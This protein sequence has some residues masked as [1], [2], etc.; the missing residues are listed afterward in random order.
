MRMETP[1]RRIMHILAQTRHVLICSKT[2]EIRSIWYLIGDCDSRKNGVSAKFNS[3][4]EAAPANLVK[5]RLY[6][7]YLSYFCPSTA[8]LLPTPGRSV[9]V[10]NGWVI[11]YIENRLHPSVLDHFSHAIDGD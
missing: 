11:R 1:R 3:L 10:S 5:S 6:R 8:T 9:L 4:V 2:S 7:S